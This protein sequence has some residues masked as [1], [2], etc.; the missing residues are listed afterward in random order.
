MPFSGLCDVYDLYMAGED[1]QHLFYTREEYL[2]S[3]DYV[4]NTWLSRKTK[5]GV[6]T[7]TA[8]SNY[9][10]LVTPEYRFVQL[11]EDGI[12]VLLQGWSEQATFATETA[13]KEL[14]TVR[15]YARA[16]GAGEDDAVYYDLEP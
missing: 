1:I 9:G 7:F 6:T 11:S 16:L 5:D 3:I 14:G 10:T 13:A 15:V 8:D 2:A 12:E 4:T